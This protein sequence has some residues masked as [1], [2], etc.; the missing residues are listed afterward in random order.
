MNVYV[1]IDIDPAGSFSEIFNYTNPPVFEFYMDTEIADTAGF[2]WGWWNIA[3][4][5][6]VDLATYL[7]PDSTEKF[8]SLYKYNGA[9]MPTWAEGEFEW[10][11]AVPLGVN[12]DENALEFSI[13]RNMVNFGTEFRIFIY[14]VADWDWAN[15]ADNLPDP[16]A[17]NMLKYDFM[18]G[19]MVYEH[20]GEQINTAIT[21]D[22]EL[23]DWDPAYQADL[24]EIAED[25]GDM[26]TGP[27][28]DIQDVYVTSDTTNLYMRVDINPA[29]TFSGIFT[30][31]EYWSAVQLFLETNWGG[32]TGLGYGGFWKVPPDYLVDFSEV[33]SPDT[34]A[35]M[36]PL[37]LYIADYDGAFEDWEW[38]GDVVEFAV[39]EEENVIEFAIPR[40]AINV[41]TDVRPWC[42]FVGNENWDV[43]EYWP[44]SVVEGF[45]EAPYHCYN[46][47]FI[48]GGSVKAFDDPIP[49]VTA[50]EKKPVMQLPGGFGLV[51]NYPNPFNPN[52]T[53]EFIL[54]KSERVTVTIYDILGK[55]VTTLIDNQ[56]RTPGVQQVNWSGVNDAGEKVGSG[57]YLY[58]VKTKDKRVVN[59]MML[60]K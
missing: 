22:G 28:F 45:E 12:E 2:D 35:N 5:Y 58:E 46:Y 51:K 30:N 15:G 33:L 57:I 27:E 10:L 24:N 25:L 8:G 55:V 44:N 38:V 23:L 16:Y 18:D 21:I 14:Y 40:T 29:A 3:M 36:A 49:L 1:R 4:N 11:G 7:R 59:K 34:V 50:V 26:S 31:Y 20:I 37:Y 52:T 60:L 53:I 47:N 9:R 41:D 19:A 54:N 56:H 42:Y 48:T 17:D 6:Y 32:F 13:P 43:E 39:N